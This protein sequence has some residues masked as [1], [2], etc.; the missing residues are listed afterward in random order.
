[1]FQIINRAG[2]IADLYP[3][4]SITVERN[5][6][7]FNDND[8]FFEDIT[9]GF[10][11]PD[12]EHNR[13][14]FGSGHL[15]EAENMVYEQDIQTVYSGGPFY[16]G[17][18]AYSYTSGEFSALIKVNFGAL[19]S[20]VNVK[21]SEIFTG[22]SVPGYYNGAYMKTVCQN[23]L[24]YPYSFFPV[25]NEG[26]DESKGT[27][28][29][30]VN[31]WDHASQ[32]FSV[33]GSMERGDT[34]ASCPYWKLKHYIVKVMQYLG[35]ICA[36]TWMDDPESEKIYVYGRYAPFTLSIYDSTVFL[37]KKLTIS[38]F[39]K[40]IRE[41]FGIAFSFNLLEG[42]VSVQS[43]N[44]IL[45]STEVIDISRY[46]SEI[47]EIN[48]PE[49]DG[50]TI[51]LVA[52]DQDELF[53]DPV[54]K[55]EDV[56]IP[57]NRMIIGSGET[58]VEIKSSTLKS[59]TVDD[60]SMPAT[61]QIVFRFPEDDIPEYPLRFMR[62]AGMKNVAGGK[63][64]PQAEP[65]ELNASDAKWYRFKNDTKPLKITA[66]IPAH[67]LLKIDGSKKIGITSKE[68]AY[69]EAIVE[70][71]TFNIENNDDEYIETTFDCH[72]VVTNLK[73]PVTIEPVTTVLADGYRL[74]RFKAYYDLNETGLDH[75]D[76]D[77]YYEKETSDTG[78]DPGH[79]RIDS[80]TVLKSTDKW[81]VGGT[82]VNFPKVFA[83]RGSVVEV[84]VKTG[85]PKYAITA[86]TKVY[87]THRDDYWHA[88]LV[89]TNGAGTSDGR[90]IWI[91]F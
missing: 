50:F 19:A 65:M 86:G 32:S 46:I 62:Y 28:H 69:K 84:R 56:Y 12:T 91:V 24:L 76:I 78:T 17:K 77:I 1:M 7:L 74:P 67:E 63:V 44:S 31:P 52:D 89:G 47:N 51:T 35:F 61:K 48:V 3:K 11:V 83:I 29:F 10:S 33:I 90:P 14:F 30:L 79:V 53:K 26:W 23:P 27:T 72:T 42:V 71:I 45:A 75:I 43:G 37:P 8:K 36:G 34:T 2:L 87:F 49:E 81:G 41:R 55:S 70:K 18:I 66:S 22:D 54:N 80:G 60:Y 59:K 25:Y 82:T 6:P 64:F 88:A 13:E 85:T 21:M 9:Y 38:E 57:T 39:F 16:A 58:E 68:N 40:L 15:I 73:T 4:T 20:K 5:N